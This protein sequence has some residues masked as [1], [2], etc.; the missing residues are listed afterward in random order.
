MQHIDRATSQPTVDKYMALWDLDRRRTK[1]SSSCIRLS[2]LQVHG[3]ICMHVPS[4]CIPNAIYSLHTHTHKFYIIL[5]SVNK[6]QQNTFLSTY[7]KV[8]ESSL[9]PTTFFPNYN[10]F[11]F[12]NLKFDHSSYS[13]KL[14]KISLLLL[15]LAL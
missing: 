8:K 12:F 5:S 7:F 11:D 4:C 6:Q 3:P 1:V 13:K 14:C 10:L 2:R 9:D 15:C